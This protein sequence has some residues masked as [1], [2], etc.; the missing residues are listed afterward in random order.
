MLRSQPPDVI[1][2]P[3]DRPGLTDPLGDHRGRHVR[4]VLQQL[5]HGRLKRGNDV[6]TAGRSNFGGLSEA[7]A[8]AT[9]DRPTPRSRATW[10]CGTPS[11]TSPNPPQRSPIQSVWVASF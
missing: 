10:R 3:T 2:E 1:A 8:R 4:R 7:N 9:D 5:P 6:V 11:A